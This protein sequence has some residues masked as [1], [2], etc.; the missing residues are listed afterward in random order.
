MA[1][2]PLLVLC[3]VLQV[4]RGGFYKWLRRRNQ[5]TERQIQNEVLKMHIKKIFSDHK[6]RYGAV[7]VRKELAK[8]EVTADVRRVSRIMRENNLVCV[9]TK[10]FKVNTTNSKHTSPIA[11]NVLNRQFAVSAPGQVWV[12]DITYIQT[13]EGWMY[14]AVILDLFHRRIVGYETSRKIDNNLVIGALEKACFQQKPPAN[15]LFHSDRGVQYASNDFRKALADAK[16]T[17][18]MSRKANCWDNA[19]AESFFATLKKELIQ[20]LPDDTTGFQMEREL[21]GYIHAYY[22][23]IRMHSTLDY[24]S[25]LEY[26]RVHCNAV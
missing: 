12:A 13:L 8:L 1:E 11:D 15:L 17:Q 14:L 7:R 3:S 22:N 2:Y 16:F 10:K 24:L 18:S 21:F 26:E 9:H 5:V 25:P 19:P 23:T 4:S 20:E 6:R